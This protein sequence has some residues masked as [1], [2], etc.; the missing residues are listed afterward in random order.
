MLRCKCPN[1]HIMYFQYPVDLNFLL[2]LFIIDLLR[3]S[4]H[5]KPYQVTCYTKCRSRKWVRNFC[6]IRELKYVLNNKINS[7]EIFGKGEWQS[8]RTQ[9]QSNDRKHECT[10]WINNFVLRVNIND[11]SRY[12][13][14]DT[15][16][17]RSR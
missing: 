12:Q 7:F 16:K 3:R 15:L 4:F 17:Y 11:N 13:D 8:F 14:S 1:V 10:D 5:D 6:S 9:S 2:Y